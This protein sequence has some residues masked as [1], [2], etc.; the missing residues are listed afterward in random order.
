MSRRLVVLPLALAAALCLTA[1]APAATTDLT[2]PLAAPLKT[3]ITQTD[4]TVLA[5]GA[6]N[7]DYSGKL[8]VS[9]AGDR[10]SYSI[11]IAGAPKCGGATA[12]FLAEISAVR[13]K[14]L[15]AAD[16]VKL[17]ITGKITGRYQKLSCGASCSPPSLSWV[18]AGNRYEIQAKVGGKDPKLS[19]AQAARSA[20][21]AGP[22]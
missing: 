15:S 17:P 11:A 8:Y 16:G 20:I 19:L 6:I 10:T 9:T 12:C 22:R 7:L 21:T 4:I 14:R 2:V 1:S 3:L 5:P 13:G 18:F